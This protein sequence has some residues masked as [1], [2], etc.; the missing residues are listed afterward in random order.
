MLVTS[1]VLLYEN[2]KNPYKMRKICIENFMRKYISIYIDKS[3]H[4]RILENSTFV[5]ETGIKDRDAYHI[6][7]AQIAHCD[8]FLSTDDRLL[9]YP[10]VDIK[11]VNPIDFLRM[12]ADWQ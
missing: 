3:N 10:S 8:Y 2:S 1:Y 12:E 7:C 4:Q 5:I 9:K 11:I 6:A